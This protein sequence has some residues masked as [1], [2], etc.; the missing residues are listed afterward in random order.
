M[1]WL[2][3]QFIIDSSDLGAVYRLM[4][5][6]VIKKM[7][8]WPENQEQPDARKFA[9]TVRKQNGSKPHAARAPHNSGLRIVELSVA[10]MQ[11]N[12]DQPWNSRDVGLALEN[13]YGKD[14]LSVSSALSM[15]KR[16]GYVNHVGLSTYQL[17]EKGRNHPQGEP[18]PFNLGGGVK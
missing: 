3:C 15:L 18:L 11:S 8:T 2:K 5:D 17:T 13:D 9:E 1:M 10:I 14:R 6:G 7:T 12:P 16:Y 4:E